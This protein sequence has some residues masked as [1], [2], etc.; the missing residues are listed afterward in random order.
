[1]EADLLALAYWLRVRKSL[2]SDKRDRCLDREISFLD[3]YLQ[4]MVAQY[5]INDSE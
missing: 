2:D 5:F 3:M 4:D 1:M